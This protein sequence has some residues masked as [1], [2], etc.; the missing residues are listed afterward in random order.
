MTAKDECHQV[1][2]SVRACSWAG[3]VPLCLWSRWSGG[4]VTVM[5]NDVPVRESA[6]EGMRPCDFCGHPVVMDSVDERDCPVCGEAAEDQP[7]EAGR[8][9]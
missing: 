3:G 1:S 2:M 6:G 7:A 5:S 9:S 4:T 8:G